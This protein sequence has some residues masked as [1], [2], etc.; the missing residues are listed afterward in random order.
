VDLIEASKDLLDHLGR[1]LVELRVG[2]GLVQTFLFCF[3]IPDSSG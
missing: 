2:C 1:L 3:Q